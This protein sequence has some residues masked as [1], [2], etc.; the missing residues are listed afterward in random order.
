MCT[1]TERQKVRCIDT[2]SGYQDDV[3]RVDRSFAAVARMIGQ[4]A[5][6]LIFYVLEVLTVSI[7]GPCTTL[8]LAALAHFPHGATGA[9]HR[10]VV[11]E[12]A[13]IVVA[14]PHAASASRTTSR[15]S[16]P[17]IVD[18]RTPNSR[19]M[20]LDNSDCDGQP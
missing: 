5:V 7:G 18:G 20:A 9:A 6:V 17:T 19:F 13:I 4:C 1:T 2:A 14:L 8:P 12:W 3:V 11:L 15:Q 16:R 10:T